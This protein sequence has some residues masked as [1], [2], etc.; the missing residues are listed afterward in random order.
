MPD[1]TE[2]PADDL[3]DGAAEI[4]AFIEKLTER[5]VYHYQKQLGLTHLGGKLIGSKKEI[6]RR[7]S[8]RGV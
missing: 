1:K 4:A 2:S 3:L 8:G 5:Q 6:A 7:L